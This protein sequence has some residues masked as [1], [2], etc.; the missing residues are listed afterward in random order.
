MGE[1]QSEDVGVAI[2]E[3]TDV[4]ADES[5]AVDAALWERI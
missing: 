5:D 1:T 3:A 4:P 2:A